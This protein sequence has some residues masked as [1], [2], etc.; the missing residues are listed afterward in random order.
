LTSISPLPLMAGD[1]IVDLA[2]HEASVT[3]N[4][5]AKTRAILVWDNPDA[6]KT[7]IVL[8]P[9]ASLPPRLRNSRPWMT[10]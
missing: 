8:S 6:P 9:L 7:D 5:S 4:V 2:L 10:C 3:D 1:V